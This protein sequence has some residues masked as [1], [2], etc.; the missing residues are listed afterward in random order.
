LFLICFGG[1]LI[2]RRGFVRRGG[3][4]VVVVAANNAVDRRNIVDLV[5]VFFMCGASA[6]V[7]RR[8]YKF[9]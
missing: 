8:S 5:C 1:E 9:K 2:P 7:G 4:V 6:S 3:V